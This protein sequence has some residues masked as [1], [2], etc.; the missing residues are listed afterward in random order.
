MNELG[1]IPPRNGG[2]KVTGKSIIII[3]AGL[4]GLSTGCY[5]Q[6]NG[7]NTRRHPLPDMPQAR[8]VNL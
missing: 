2:R 7:Y 6:M 5:A 1:E 8:S 4:A 3:G